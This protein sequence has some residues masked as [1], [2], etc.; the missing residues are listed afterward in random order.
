M[1]RRPPRSTRTDTLFPYTTLFRSLARLVELAN[2]ARARI[3]APVV[4]L[5]LHLVLDDRALL[6]DD[7]DFLQALGEAPDAFALERPGHADL[8][9]G[10][11]DLP[12][13]RL[14]DAEVVQGLTHVEIGLAGG[15]D[16]R[17]EERR[18]G[19]E[20]VSTCRSGWAP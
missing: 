17:S 2:H 9:D 12:G 19:Q 16:A 3:A 6:L 10:K 18:V 14:V 8:V 7:Q 4:K 11:A 20:G 5:L 1:I 15:D 13:T